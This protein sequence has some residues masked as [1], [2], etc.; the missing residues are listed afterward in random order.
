[1]D[2]KALEIYT[3]GNFMVLNKKKSGNIILDK[4]YI[5]K[6]PSLLF[7]Y[8]LTY[9]DKFIH[10]EILIEV[11]W[12]NSSLEKPKHALTNL[13]YRLRQLLKYPDLI[14][15]EQGAYKF[16]SEANYWF[17]LEVF[18]NLCRQAQQYKNS[19]MQKAIEFYKRAFSLYRGDYLP[20]CLYYDWVIPVRNNY[21]WFYVENVLQYLKLLKNS[22]DKNGNKYLEI[23][24]ICELA[25]KIEPLEEKLNI[26]LIE[27]LINQG[28]NTHARRH[29]KYVVNLFN[30]ELDIEP[31]L[32]LSD[33]FKKGE[34]YLSTPFNDLVNIQENLEETRELPGAFKCPP[35]IF[36]NI[37]NIEHRKARRK[38]YSVY[39]GSLSVENQMNHG[40]CLT[41]LGKNISENLR[42]GDV[43]TQ[44]NK[45][46]Y[47]ILIS[48]ITVKDME[49][50]MRRIEG[51]FMK[52]APEASYIN[53]Q[54]IKI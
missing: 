39:I 22:Q 51:A 3:L 38:E 12:P 37:Y 41:L 40:K 46:L 26:Y 1:M 13:V 50:I 45:N 21:H 32:E 42:Q 44:W 19:D 54:Y 9:R 20:E 10:P 28:E 36:K 35:D 31:T 6:K 17:D 53:N 2:E 52:L 23:S 18:E 49:K 16:N 47:L 15:T 5:D 25:L 34:N 24:Q 30:K 4:K 48:E 11:L 29:Y 8:L 43:F 7:K 27:S 33:L 14:I